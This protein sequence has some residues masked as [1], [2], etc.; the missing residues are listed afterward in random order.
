MGSLL[1]YMSNEKK[2]SK[3]INKRSTGQKIVINST[4]IKV[5]PGELSTIE[6]SD[7]KKVKI[8]EELNS[9]L[10]EGAHGSVHTAKIYQDGGGISSYAVK[11]PSEEF[12]EEKRRSIVHKWL[13]KINR[14]KELGIENVVDFAEIIDDKFFLT[15]LRIY[16]EVLDFEH[17]MNRNIVN[18]FDSIILGVTQDLAKIHDGGLILSDAF[19]TYGFRAWFLLRSKSRDGFVGERVICDVGGIER[20]P[21]DYLY[22]DFSN[23]KFISEI[24]MGYKQRN[25]LSLFSVCSFEDDLCLRIYNEYINNVVKDKHIKYAH[26]IFSKLKKDKSEIVE[27]FTDMT[28]DY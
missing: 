21:S 16:G 26:D 14:L 19:G 12:K 24:K 2:T 5:K 17:N 7:F 27:T 20:F 4:D 8:I 1:I 6:K 28:L 15:D 13:R 3:T 22:P 25:L 10:G 23:K 11:E 9:F 18:N